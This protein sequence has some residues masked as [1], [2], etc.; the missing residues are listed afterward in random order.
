MALMVTTEKVEENNRKIALIMGIS[1]QDGN[2]L[3]E[4]LVDKGYEVHGLIRH[5]ST[6]NTKSLHLINKRFSSQ[7]KSAIILHYGDLND[8]SSIVKVILTVR[9]NEVYNLAAMRHD[10]ISFHLDEY[11][12]NLNG[13]GALR[14]L[15][16]IRACGLEK[17]IRFYQASTSELYGKT[18]QIP[19]NENTPFYPRSPYG[20]YPLLLAGKF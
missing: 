20:Q 18:Y 19:Q 2:Y 13:L 9:P 10:E 7:G 3:A 5:S 4:L 12:V 16:A 11:T 14:I 15:D 17:C 8:T 6:L 1:G